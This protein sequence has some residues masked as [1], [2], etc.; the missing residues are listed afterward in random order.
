MKK[1]FILIILL[2]QINSCS[3]K[4]TEPVSDP[5]LSFSPEEVTMSNNTQ[6]AVT[7]NIADISKDIFAI[8]MRLNFDDNVLSFD[9]NSG[10]SVGDFFGQDAIHLV[11]VSESNIHLSISLTQGASP[12]KGTGAICTL[13]FQCIATGNCMLTINEDELIFYDAAGSA[14]EIANLSIGSSSISVE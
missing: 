4:S 1:I 8:S 14:I 6:T 2:I 3:D 5:E 11:K 7:V 9:E 13:T 12:I 10:C